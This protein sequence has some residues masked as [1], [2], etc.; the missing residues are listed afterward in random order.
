ME[1]MTKELKA[2]IEN[3]SIIV[4]GKELF[5]KIKIK[6]FEINPGEKREFNE[7]YVFLYKKNRRIAKRNLKNK[8]FISFFKIFQRILFYF[9]QYFF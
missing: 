8:I 3:I 2:Q 6:S 1:K 9:I 4:N 7:E 5:L